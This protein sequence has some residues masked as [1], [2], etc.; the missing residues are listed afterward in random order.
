MSQPCPCGGPSYATCCEPLHDGTAHAWTSEQLMRARYSAYAVD[1]P[2]YVFRT[3]HPRT[4]PQAVESTPLV[5]TGLVIRD[6]LAG[7][8]DDDTGVVEFEASYT[9]GGTP[10]VLRE[11]S[12]FERRKSRWVYVDAE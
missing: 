5:W 12:R 7:G 1:R 3:W 10:G 11:R 8:P 2:H 4:R 9:D 6:V